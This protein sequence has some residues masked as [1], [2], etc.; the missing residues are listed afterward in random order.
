[1]SNGHWTT[2]DPCWQNNYNEK[3][4]ANS[5]IWVNW[6]GWSAVNCWYN[7]ILGGCSEAARSFF[8]PE[9]CIEKQQTASIFSYLQGPPVWIVNSCLLT[10]TT[11]GWVK[12]KT[13]FSLFSG[14]HCGDG[15]AEYSLPSILFLE[16]QVRK[17]Q[18]GIAMRAWP[19]VVPSIIKRILVCGVR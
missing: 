10:M 4:L 15:A 3:N 9:R 14:V 2:L 13:P 12:P 5:L 16:W 11:F 8:N 7:Q 18:M 17:L 19:L 6:W 1:M